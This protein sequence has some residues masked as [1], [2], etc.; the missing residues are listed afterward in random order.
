MY[1]R[2]VIQ[3]FILG[4]GWPISISKR[5][6]SYSW[7]IWGAR[8]ERPCQ[9]PE[10]LEHLIHIEVSVLYSFYFSSVFKLVPW[11]SEW[12][13]TGLIFYSC[14]YFNRLLLFFFSWI[15]AQE[16][17]LPKIG[18]PTSLLTCITPWK[19]SF[20]AKIVNGF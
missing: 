14:W 11:L 17:C 5:C 10:L 4:V 15:W 20:F 12:K 13:N 7:G 2:G 1:N 6:G 3:E 18:I 9:K 19:R 8:C 16:P